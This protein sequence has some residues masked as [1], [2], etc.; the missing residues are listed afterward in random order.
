MKKMAIA[1]IAAAMI[2]GG[3]FTYF[4]AS[5]SDSKYDQLPKEKREIMERKEHNKLKAKNDNI[6][7]ND[8]KNGPL[9]IQHDREVTTK[10][11]SHIEDPVYDET[12]TFTNGWISSINKN[13]VKGRI[14]TVEAGVLKQNPK[15]GIVIVMIDGEKRKFAGAKQY[16]TPSKNGAV[17]VIGYNGFNL[18]LEAKDGKKWS[19]NVSTG[20]FR[21]IQ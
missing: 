19:F 16:L 10:I 12:I 9:V 4:H 5:A 15:Q 20:T 13:E 21:N 3:G 14:V 11:I 17:K 2:C 8:G 1:S 6:T 7:K 18:K